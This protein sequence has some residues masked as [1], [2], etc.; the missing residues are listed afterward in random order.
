MF[1][2]HG[3]SRLEGGVLGIALQEESEVEGT[4]DKETD[5][6]TDSQVESKLELALE[7]L[8]MASDMLELASGEEGE[9][10]EVEITQGE[11]LQ[12]CGEIAM[13][14][15]NYEQAAVDFSLCLAVRQMV[16]PADSR[17]YFLLLSCS[18]ALL[19]SCSL[20]LSGLSPRHST[21]WE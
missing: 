11:V 6:K 7:T 8:E 2:S 5:K 15:E 13:E 4:K 18:L 20:A 1:L 10:K 12:A 3:K 21:S 16:L 19:L 17:Y 9:R 14:D